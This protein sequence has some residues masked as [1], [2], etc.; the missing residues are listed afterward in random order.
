[1]YI[2][3]YIYIALSKNTTG[4]LKR[5]WFYMNWMGALRLVGDERDGRGENWMN[6]RDFIFLTVERLSGFCGFLVNK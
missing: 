6:T 5:G 2:C 4:Y 3:M 1:M